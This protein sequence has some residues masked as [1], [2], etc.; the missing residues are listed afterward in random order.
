MHAERITLVPGLM[1]GRP[2][3]CGMRFAVA[4]VLEYL[5]GGMTTEELLAEFPFLEREDVLACLDYAAKQA[6]HEFIPLDHK[7]A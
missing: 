4:D 1:G 3:V 6:R 5:A 2:T 7:A